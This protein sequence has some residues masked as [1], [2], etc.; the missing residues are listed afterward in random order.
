MKDQHLEVFN[1]LKVFLK[2]QATLDLIRE[3]QDFAFLQKSLQITY[4]PVKFL[5][6]V[7]KDKYLLIYIL[8]SLIL[9]PDIYY[10]RVIQ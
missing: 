1:H 3:D 10:D 4:H 2:L 6:L 7:F 9:F 5:L 8:I